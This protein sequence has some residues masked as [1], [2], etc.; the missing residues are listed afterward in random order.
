MKLKILKLSPEKAHEFIEWCGMI[1]G[2]KGTDSLQYNTRIYKQNLYG[3]FVT[4]YPDYG[5]KAKMTISRTK[6]YKWLK[7][8]ALFKTNKTPEEGKDMQGRWIIIKN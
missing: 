5:P 3:E 7:A 4:E 6:F 2:Q 8:Y 1:N